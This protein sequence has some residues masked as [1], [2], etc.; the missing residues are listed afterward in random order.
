MQRQGFLDATN[1]VLQAQ[2]LSNLCH[3]SY[4]KIFSNVDERLPLSQILAMI[5]DATLKYV[6]ARFESTNAIFSAT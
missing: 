4:L 5:L 2:G 6:Y 3:K 1:T